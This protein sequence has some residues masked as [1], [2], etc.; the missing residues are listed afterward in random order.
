MTC[1][2]YTDGFIIFK[3]W[4][5]HF[6]QCKWHHWMQLIKLQTTSSGATKDFGWLFSQYFVFIYYSFSRNNSQHKYRYDVAVSSFSSAVPVWRPPPLH[7]LQ[8]IWINYS[9]PNTSQSIPSIKSNQDETK[10]TTWKLNSDPS[11]DNDYPNQ[12]PIHFLIN[13]NDK[14]F[15]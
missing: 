1:I 14:I 15:L 7:G 6:P 11:N 9:K 13:Y 5:L 10:R 4:C 8:K 12:I 2:D 3:I